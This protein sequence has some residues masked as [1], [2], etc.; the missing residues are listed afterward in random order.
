MK[1]KSTTPKKKTGKKSPDHFFH[2]LTEDHVF[3]D[4][5]KMGGHMPLSSPRQ[6]V[7]LATVIDLL[8]HIDDK[9]DRLTRS[10]EDKNQAMQN[11]VAEWI[12]RFIG[13]MRGDITNR[14]NAIEREAVADARKPKRRSAKVTEQ[15]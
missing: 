15:E 8:V 6:G 14:I 13:E 11:D 2:H 9:I 1:K 7:G 10:I 5:I 3:A 4:H 12:N